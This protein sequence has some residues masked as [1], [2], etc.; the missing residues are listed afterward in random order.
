MT[1]TVIGNGTRREIDARE[2]ETVLAALR[3]AGLTAPEAPC[4]GNGTCKKCLVTVDGREVLACRTAVTGDHTVVIPEQNAG[5][6]IADAGR[7]VDFP[8]TPGEG[9]GA[10][11]DIGTTTVVVHLYD[12]TSGALLGTRSGVNRQRAFGADVISRIQYAMTQADGLEQLTAA[13][14]G[15]LNGYLAELCAAAGRELDELSTVTV[16]A[17]TVMEH[18]YAGLSPA[19]IAAAP[20]TPLSLFG[21]WQ[22]GGAF[23]LPEHTRVCLAPAV[24]GYVGGDITAGILASGAYRAEQPVLFLDVGTNGEMALGSADGGFLCCATAA[25]PAFEGAAISQG[26]S[27]C[28]GAV[29]RVELTDGR[30]AVSVLGGGKATG[31]CGSGLVDAL[32][33]MLELGAVD[34]TGRLL[35]P[36]EAPEEALPYLEEDEDGGVRFRLAGDVCI[37]DADVRQLQLAKAAIAAGICTLLDEA[38]LTEDDIACLYLAGGFGNYIRRESAAAIGLLP[39]SMVERIVGVG[40]SAG[41]GAAAALLSAQARDILDGLPGRCRYIELSGHKAFNDYYIDCMMFE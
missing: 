26:M 34:E 29:S 41:Q 15:Q 18:I 31:V 40:N 20:F 4:G 2:G 6:V 11:V 35:P 10:A 5:A 23:G 37:T 8:L 3:R 36:D 21:E 25:G 17:N 7:G 12:R 1:L 32:A 9:L 27:A 38:G 30:V 28:D 14:R 16:A 19:S 24:A 13:I 39:P 22:D 33:V